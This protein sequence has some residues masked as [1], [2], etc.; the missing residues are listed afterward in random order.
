MAHPK[1]KK[2]LNTIGYCCVCGLYR[3]GV[4][5]MNSNNGNRR[6][7]YMPEIPNE[8]VF[9]KMVAKAFCMILQYAKKPKEQRQQQQKIC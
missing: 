5:E 4:F 7:I 6:E 2:K 9:S 8:C 3:P 1:Q